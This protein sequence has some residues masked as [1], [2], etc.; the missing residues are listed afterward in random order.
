MSG[1]NAISPCVSLISSASRGADRSG[2]FEKQWVDLIRSWMALL[3]ALVVAM[4][5]DDSEFNA[6]LRAS[7]KVNKRAA[8]M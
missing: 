8:I 5:M 1:E 4:E 3:M 6:G 2:E 7:L